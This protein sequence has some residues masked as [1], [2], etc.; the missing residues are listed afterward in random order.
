M[1][2]EESEQRRFV[3][4]K[5]NFPLVLK[6]IDTKREYGD[7]ADVR[8]LDLSGVGMGVTLDLDDISEISKGTEVILDFQLPGSE[9]ELPPI[10]GVVVRICQAE[11]PRTGYELGIEFGD[12][13]KVD[14]SLPRN[15][16]IQDEID[17]QQIIKYVIQKEV[18]SYTRRTLRYQ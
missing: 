13:E 3:R 15:Q 5:V 2:R 6:V 7:E 11:E 14:P 8:A 17:Q 10:K 16:E 12:F 9:Y 1:R 18:H 4:T